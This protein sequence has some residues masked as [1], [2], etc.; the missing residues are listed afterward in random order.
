MASDGK[1]WTE[2]LQ[3]PRNWSGVLPAKQSVVEALRSL[4]SEKVE[5]GQP[6]IVHPAGRLE[7]RQNV[8][9]LGVRLQKVGNA[10]ITGP[11][12]FDITI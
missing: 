7:V 9:P 3:D 12:W 2:V 1:S 5:G 11:D 10:P 6:I 8:L 4:E